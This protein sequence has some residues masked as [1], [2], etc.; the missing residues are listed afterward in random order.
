MIVVMGLVLTAASNGLGRHIQYVEP[1]QAVKAIMML[2]ISEFFLIICTVFVKF[3][4][5]LF[6]LRIF[7]ASK[8]WKIFLWGFVIFNTVT[9]LLDA[10]FIFPQCT[11]V[12][13]NWDKSIPGGH[14]WSNEAIDGTGIMQGSIAAATDFILS[15]LP[16]FFLWDIQIK[17]RVKIGICAV[18]AV[19]V[20]SGAFAVVRTVLVPGLVATHDPT[21]DLVPLF[22]WAL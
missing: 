10:A 4:I 21:W 1:E 5:C 6:L 8:P 20:A 14:C 12:A 22:M 18:M 17:L 2:R 16:I 15:L 7:T 9:S 11:P 19:G 13:F 3:S